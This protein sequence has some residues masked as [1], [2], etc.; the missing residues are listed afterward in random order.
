MYKLYYYP[1][2]ASMAPHFV[3][4]ALNV[5]F[6]LIL[7]DRKR[8]AQKSAEY[9][10][11]NPAGRIPTLIDTELV[12]FESAAICIHLAESN[13]ATNLI[14]AL[15]CNDRAKFFQWMMY[16][17]NT[18]QAELML[19]FYPEKHTDNKQAALEITAAQEARLSAILQL[20]DTELSQRDFLVGKQ[21]T[22]CDFFLFM[23]AI[24]ADE[25]KQPPLAFDN[26]SRYLCRLARHSA[27][28]NV[29]NKEGLSLEDYQ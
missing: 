3:L 22:V 16:L 28:I 8:N 1:L 4:E 10:A 24:W 20:L 19:Y 6:E 21:V 12:L 18:L 13:P 23:L 2:N 9:L 27:I 7:V 15:G 17:T 25:L 5:D 29:C 26:L 11:L 14:P